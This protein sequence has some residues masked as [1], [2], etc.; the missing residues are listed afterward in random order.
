MHTE[1]MKLSELGPQA[2]N[3]APKKYM[4]YCDNCGKQKVDIGFNL[5]HMT[6]IPLANVPGG[7]PKLS[8]DGKAEHRP[9]L[10]R[11]KMVKC[12]K[13]GRGVTVRGFAVPESNHTEVKQENDNIIKK[14][15]VERREIR[16]AGS[17]I[18][19]Y[20]AR[21]APDGC[22]EVPEQSGM[23]VQPPDLPEGSEGGE[24]AIA[25]LFS[26]QGSSE[27]RGSGESGTE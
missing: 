5:Q 20:L 1:G 8:P 17:A 22:A 3:P 13:C 27:G 12:P 15:I 6:K 26:R 4:V 19:N 9:A 7:V 21:H 11:P 10:P 24:D 14:N 25:R 18:Q 2:K 16:P 23:C